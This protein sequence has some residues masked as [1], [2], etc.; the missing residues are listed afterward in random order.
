MNEL[1]TNSFSPIPKNARPFFFFS[2]EDFHFSV[3][4][5]LEISMAMKNITVTFIVY[6]HFNPIKTETYPR[7]KGNKRP[8][9]IPVKP[10]F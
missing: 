10:L 3:G 6:N 1:L 8:M 9:I 2:N 5:G 4:I 7:I